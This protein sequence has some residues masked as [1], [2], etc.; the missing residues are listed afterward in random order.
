MKEHFSIIS[1][2]DWHPTTNLLLSASTDRAVIVWEEG[3]NTDGDTFIP[4]M[5][6]TPEKKAC[7]DS[8]W[9]TTGDKFCVGS[10]SGFVYV[11]TYSDKQNFWVANPLKKKP[12]HGASVT[13]VRFD[14]QSGRA[15]ASASLDGSITITSAFV[16]GLEHPSDGPFGKVESRGEELIKLSG[17]GWVNGLAFSPSSNILA[18]VTHDCEVNFLTDLSKSINAD[19]KERPE[20]CKMLHVGNPH[21]SCMFVDD[22]TMLAAGYDKVPY[23]YK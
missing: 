6:I 12:L 13:S 16:E 10:S 21:L 8:T 7:T 4:M 14:P 3:K 11:G 1:A 5:G 9:N 18:F 23:V 20:A 15:V 17:S 22:S 2:L 19:K